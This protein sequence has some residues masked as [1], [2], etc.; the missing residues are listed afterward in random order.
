MV[1]VHVLNIYLIC[2]CC[3]CCLSALQVTRW[4]SFMLFSLGNDRHIGPELAFARI[5]FL[6]IFHFFLFALCVRHRFLCRGFCVKF[7]FGGTRQKLILQLP[8]TFFCEFFLLNFFASYFCSCLLVIICFM[9]LL[10]LGILKINTRTTAYI[11]FSSN[12]FRALSVPMYVWVCNSMAGSSFILN[13][14]RL[15]CVCLSV[16]V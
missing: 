11:H 8:I 3:C 13:S 10:R 6:L 14:I 4:P 9:G 5:F 16:W 12:G 7:S 1:Y 15:Q 2:C